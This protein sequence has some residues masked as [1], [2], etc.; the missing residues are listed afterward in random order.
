MSRTTTLLRG[1]THSD[2]MNFHQLQMLLGNRARPEIKWISELTGVSQTVAENVLE[3]MDENLSM[4]K[5]IH[6]TLRE[7]GR[8][9][10]AQ[11]PA[12]LELYAITRIMKPR[13]VVESG[14]SSGISSAHFLMALKK[15]R[16]GTL[17]SI[18]YPTYSSSPKRSKADISWTIP[19]GK[20]SGWAVEP[21]LRRR[22]KLYM[23]KSEN[24][25]RGLLRKLG[26][27]DIYCHDSPWTSRHLQY[28]VDTIRPYLH[29]GSVIIADNSS[30]NP[31]AVQQL[32]RS[33][34]ARVLHRRTS[35][36]IGIR[37]P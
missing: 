18:D 21:G 27:V 1:T 28:E 12:P 10:Y 3:E 25:L 37:V 19:Y 32:A 11:F 7:T 26:T 6:D 4:E 31:H 13:H 2:R 34:N 14:V 35:D 22:W 24:L 17:H 36:L 16:K 29:S 33:H 23:G 5:T 8:T 20:D 15:N 9:Y 30:R